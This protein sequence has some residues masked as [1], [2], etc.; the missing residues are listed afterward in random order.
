V[1]N[2]L[3]Y[4]RRPY[5]SPDID[6]AGIRVVAVRYRLAPEHP[7]PAALDDC[8]AVYSALLNTYKSN[9]IVVFGDSA[10]GALAICMLL[11]AKAAGQ[12]LPAALAVM[13][14]WADVTT[15]G[16]TY[17]TLAAT[18]PL[19]TTE[20]LKANRAAYVP[21]GVDPKNPLVSPVYGGSSYID[22]WPPTLIT[23]GTRDILL[24]CAFRLYR[25]LKDAGVRVE[26]SGW[27]GMWHNFHYWL[28]MPEGLE[29]AKEMAQFLGRHLSGKSSPVTAP[30]Q[31]L[32]AAA[33]VK[34]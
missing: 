4:E 2:I 32:G 18:D 24:S 30:R 7:Y 34:R 16:D 31:F 27:E 9:Q 19:L 22:N 13:S 3:V 26:L 25:V 21:P 20:A 6:A 33:D 23:I 12:P 29:A 5:S 11:K 15:E 10:G 17:D 28:D 14:P 8:Y 1:V